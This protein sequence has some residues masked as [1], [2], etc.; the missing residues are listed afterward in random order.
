MRRAGHFNASRWVVG[1]EMKDPAATRKFNRRFVRPVRKPFIAVPDNC[2]F[3]GTG[4]N[5]DEGDLSIGAFDCL[6]EVEIYAFVLQ[7]Q[8]TES[9]VFIG[10]KAA[11]VSGIEAQPL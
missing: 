1:V 4:I 3:T 2:P 10:A 9:P 8:Q 7:R 11:C 5:D 6:R